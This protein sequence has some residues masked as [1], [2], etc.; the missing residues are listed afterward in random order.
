MRRILLVLALVVALSGC[1]AQQ[2]QIWW[3]ANGGGSLDTQTAQVFADFYNGRCAPDYY[4]CLPHT[5]DVD[6][7]GGSGDGPAYT[8]GGPVVILGAD[9]YGLDADHDGIGCERN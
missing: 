8:N 7:L 6:C 3:A 5:S 4:P 2:V 9:P 1:S